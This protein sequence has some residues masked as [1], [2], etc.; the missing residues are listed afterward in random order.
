VYS[1]IAG[2]PLK[3]FEVLRDACERAPHPVTP[4]AAIGAAYLPRERRELGASCAT[5]NSRGGGHQGA[6]D[7]NR[8]GSLIV[9]VMAGYT[10]SIESA[11]QRA[12]RAGRRPKP[13]RQP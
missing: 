7:R 4:C 10:G 11:W 3:F 9:V 5:V 1:R 13:R 2:W 12:G 6:R 8:I